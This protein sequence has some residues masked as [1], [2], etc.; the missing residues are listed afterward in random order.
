MTRR[1]SL[2]LLPAALLLA[3]CGGARKP[4]GM[5]TLEVSGSPDQN[6]DSAGD[7]EPVAVRIYQL[8]AIRKFE[9]SGWAALTEREQPTLG[10]DDAGSQEVVVAPEQNVR[11]TILLQPDVQAIGIVVLYRDIG[12]AQWRALAPVAPTGNTRLAVHVGK[13]AVS[14]VAPPG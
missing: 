11:R 5:L 7:P 10:A 2:L 13:Q 4:P 8:R 3:R 1:R 14:L 9:T 12:H 6:P